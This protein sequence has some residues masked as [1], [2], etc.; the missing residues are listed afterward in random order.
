MLPGIVY[1]QKIQEFK[2]ELVN[3]PPGAGVCID[4]SNE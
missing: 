3:P 1:K 2:A 4:E